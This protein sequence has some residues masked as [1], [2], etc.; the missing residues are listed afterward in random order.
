MRALLAL[1]MLTAAP[2]AAETIYISDEEANVIHVIDGETLKVAARVPVG[3]RP[4]GMGLSKDG[5]TLYVAVS[6]DNRIDA[7]DLASK[8]VVG[9]L[10]SGPD[11]ELFVLHPSGGQL[12]V[13]NED[14][15]LVSFVDVAG[16][17]ITR[18][19]TV[20]TEPEGMAVSPDGRLVINT[21][22][23]S[24]MV[25][26]ID[27]ASGELID[28]IMVDTRPRFARFAPDGKRL[29]VT[30][31]VRA[32]LSVIDVATRK[33]VGV[34]DFEALKL[35]AEILQPVG[36]EMTRDGRRAFVALGRGRLVAEVDP[37]TLK[38]LRTYEVGFR[39]WNLA[40]SPDETRLYTAN[41]LD[42]DM[43]VI[44]IVAN[45]TVGSVK[46]GGKPWGIVVAP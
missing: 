17:R 16:R 13:A 14:D 45:R 5:R 8:R 27:A 11:P 46:L 40:L 7:L 29:W 4:R 44:D 33:I 2:A 34:L 24:S 41:G 19:V 25:H 10:P 1:V 12:F 43:S 35:P 22:E 37:Q 38:L 23:A 15:N 20:G 31:E 21:S 30:S 18:E 26:F 28:N 9:H 36:I 39:A 42:G 3:Q 6:N 32:T